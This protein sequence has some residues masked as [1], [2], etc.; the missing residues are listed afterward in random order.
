MT[1]ATTR[2]MANRA[3]RLAKKAQKN[4]S[5][6]DPFADDQPAD[7]TTVSVEVVELVDGKPVKKTVTVPKS[8]LLA[9]ANEQ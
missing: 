1:A 4:A 3:K 9:L 6:S 7:E 8:K 5:D 2:K